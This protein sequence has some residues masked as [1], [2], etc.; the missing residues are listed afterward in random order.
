MKSLSEMVGNTNAFK[1]SEAYELFTE[2]NQ[3]TLIY[4][5]CEVHSIKLI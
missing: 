1:V 2:F 4:R 3:K 5:E